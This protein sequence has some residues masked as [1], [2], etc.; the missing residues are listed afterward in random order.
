[1]KMFGMVQKKT[2][3]RHLSTYVKN[4]DIKPGYKTDNSL[5]T[6]SINLHV[7][8]RGPGYWK[9]NTSLLSEIEYI[10]W[11][12]SAIAVVQKEYENDNNVDDSLLWEMI[13]LKVRESS[14]RYVKRKK[15]L[16]KNQEA[17][18]EN[19]ITQLTKVLETENTSSH[20]KSKASES[21]DNKKRQFENINEYKRKGTIIRSKARWYNEGEKTNNKYF[22]NLEKRHYKQNIIGQLETSE[23]TLTKDEDILKECKRFYQT[24]YT[25]TNPGIDQNQGEL[26]FLFSGHHNKLTAEE[27]HSCE[28]LLT[29]N[30][31][32]EALQ[33]MKNVKSPGND[34]LPSEFY[35][36]F[37]KDI[38]AAFIK[39]INR[40]CSGGKL[41]ISQR[42]V[43][44]KLIH[45]KNSI[46][47]K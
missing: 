28:G 24:L 27:S 41:S 15:T 22:L 29:E 43:T 5:N 10:E 3:G 19:E 18:L 31:C 2:V 35:K 11:I 40:S 17:K 37:W 23:E 45:K 44:I 4:T 26:F 8:P 42:R 7:N 39:A 13:K 12:K 16:M 21:L 25:S 47:S 30:E 32:L 20:V 9:L 38:S 6:L 46:L 14:I 1:M 33:K 36:M 34:G